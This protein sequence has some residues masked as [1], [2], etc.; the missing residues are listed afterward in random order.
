MGQAVCRSKETGP[1]DVVRVHKRPAWHPSFPPEELLDTQDVDRL[2][3]WF[4]E[5]LP[6]MRPGD[7][8][9]TSRERQLQAMSLTDYVAARKRC[10]VTCEEYTSA[11]VKRMVHFSYM[12]A[13]MY[14][15]SMPQQTEYIVQQARELDKKARDQ[16]V[17]AIAPL[18]G[19]PV[20]AK[21]TMA[22]MDFP[23]SAGHGLLHGCYAK[24]DAAMVA[25]LRSKHAV[26]MGKTNVPEFAA[27]FTTANYANGCTM[28]PYSHELIPGGS[29]GG[30]ASA[31][32]TYI[33]PL[34]ISEDTGGSTRGPALQNQSFGY[35]PS[36]HHY[37][38]DGNA[39]IT[40][41]NDQIGLIARSL[42]DIIAMDA[43]LLDLEAEHAAH[44]A[45]APPPGDVR[46]GLPRWPFV[47]FFVPPGCHS[48]LGSPHMRLSEAAK[49]KYEAA[50]RTLSLAGVSL[51]EGEWPATQSSS[52]GSINSLAEVLYGR[53]VNGKPCDT[54]LLTS[55]HSFSGQ[56]AQWVSQYLGAEVSLADLISDVHDM[57][58]HKPGHFLK[59][60]GQM[61]ESQFR[62]VMAIQPEVVRVYNSYF[63]AHNVDVI[64]LPGLLCDAVTWKD[65]VANTCAVQVLESGE[66]VTKEIDSV[67]PL[68][69]S[70]FHLKNIPIPKLMV[71]TGLDSHGRPTGVQIWGRA[72]PPERLYD[73][74]YARTCD[75][76][77]L[78]TAKVLIDCIQGNPHLKRVDAPLV[79]GLLEGLVSSRPARGGA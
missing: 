68:S 67:H 50:K 61:D 15:D 7:K 14:L 2:V 57:G 75:L 34:A 73:D 51:V 19:L 42:E 76:A 25:L 20:P 33:A 26:I 35:D 78:H 53:V 44:Q 46:V 18:Y 59:N 31:V 5:H 23:S 63:D 41:T 24:K 62:Y 66:W 1:R 4:S 11:L 52:L 70:M 45:A 69:V 64:L 54:G 17:S 30:A 38:N 49:T 72:V 13:F 37:P 3:A 6:A 28:N 40:Y 27:S 12:N 79:A 21:G 47:E 77:F 10:E 71:P 36:R 43:A 55:T 32:A 48:N 9:L 8:T 22:T 29:S 60:S 39:A 74:A 65:L 16:G 58:S 56:A